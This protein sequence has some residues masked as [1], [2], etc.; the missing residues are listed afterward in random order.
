MTPWYLRE[1]EAK[2]MR[3]LFWLWMLIAFA[4]GVLTSWTL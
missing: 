2:W 4:L 1:L 3:R